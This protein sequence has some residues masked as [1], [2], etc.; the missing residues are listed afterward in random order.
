MSELFGVS[1]FPEAEFSLITVT[2]VRMLYPFWSSRP[3]NDYP[4]CL[5]KVSAI[6]SHLFT[7]NIVSFSIFGLF[8]LPILYRKTPSTASPLYNSALIFR[9][10]KQ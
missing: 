6:L 4:Y 10:E 7:P 8:Y 9:T 3:L 5:Y 1:V 2:S